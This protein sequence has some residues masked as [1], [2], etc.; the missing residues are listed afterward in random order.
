MSRSTWKPLFADNSFLKLMTKQRKQRKTT[1]RTKNLS[2]WSRRS[3]I[4]P[5]SLGMK[6]SIHNG[7]RMTT[8]LIGQD[9][10]GHKLGEFVPTRK[11][12]VPKRRKKK[13][14]KKK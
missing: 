5:A 9:M 13:K 6:I 1:K 8:K 14:I 7:K 2:C 3:A 11:L 10:M 12:Y 4:Y